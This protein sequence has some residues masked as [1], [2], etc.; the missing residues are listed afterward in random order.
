MDKARIEKNIEALGDK[1]RDRLLY[2]KRLIRRQRGKV[3]VSFRF[4][5][6]VNGLLDGLLSR[7]GR[8]AFYEWLFER[9]IASSKELTVYEMFGLIDWAKPHS[10]GLH[11]WD[12]DSR[13]LVDMKIAYKVFGGGVGAME[14][15]MPA[16]PEPK[17]S[18]EAMVNELIYTPPETDE[19]IRRRTKGK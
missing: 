10:V 4:V 9:R 6:M 19:V 2:V 5:G 17:K 13:A 8:L 12:Y 1:D 15:P 18:R 14:L 16:T 7:D 11:A 3:S